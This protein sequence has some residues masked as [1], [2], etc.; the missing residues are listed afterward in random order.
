[1]PGSGAFGPGPSPQQA[2]APLGSLVSA[3]SKVTTR[4]PSCWYAGDARIFGIQVF[5]HSSA[6]AS[7]PGRPS[8]QGLSW[9]SSHRL[10]VMYDRF[11]VVAAEARSAGSRERSTSLLAH[12]GDEVMLLK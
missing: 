1:M 2:S 4:R 11:G 7:P 6:L 10:G 3:S 5:S 9:P 8:T 12:V